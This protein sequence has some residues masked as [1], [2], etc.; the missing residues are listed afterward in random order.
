MTVIKA[1]Q[2]SAVDVRQHPNQND[3]YDISAPTH[4]IISMYCFFSH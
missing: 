3:T 1:A 4:I 2:K